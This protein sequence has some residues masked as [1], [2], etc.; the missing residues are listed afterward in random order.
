MANKED[1]YGTQNLRVDG[2]GRKIKISP[3]GHWVIYRNCRI[4]CW[5]FRNNAGKSQLHGELMSSFQ[6]IYTEI[7][8]PKNNLEVFLK[9]VKKRKIDIIV[10]FASK[11]EFLI[12]EMIKNE[13][14]INL[15]VGTINYFSDPVFFEFC[16]DV[17]ND[18]DS[19]LNFS[20]DFRINESIHWKLYLISPETVIIGSSNLTSIGVSMRR[21]TAVRVQD[22]ILYD[23]YIDLIQ[24]VRSNGNVVN[25]RDIGFDDFLS[26]YKENH[27][28]K[29]LPPPKADN[30]IPITDFVNWSSRDESSLL[31]IFIWED[32]FTKQDRAIFKNN[33]I[34][35]ISDDEKVKNS[36]S[37]IGWYSSKKTNK[38]YRN[39]EV[40]LH[41]KNN[42]SYARFYEIAFA[43]YGNGRWWL[44]A[45]KYKRTK[46][47]LFAITPEFKDIIKQ[48]APIWYEN[49]KTYLNSKELR[50]IA[51]SL[52]NAQ[53]PH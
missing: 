42:G 40:V 35:K 7:I 23:D 13:N 21:D 19:N 36:I 31:P 48:H 33:I 22:K 26:R 8:Q 1:R 34:D 11:T 53:Q 2:P 51:T 9:S 12:K 52:K 27:R 46:T 50:T 4:T 20:V 32:N 49:G 5:A 29:S 39:G 15:T 6:K 10:A 3:W 24:N 41:M 37:L 30:N 25:S 14:I 45:Y 16:K 44:C 28:A 47:I 43:L 17:A 18:I 38:P